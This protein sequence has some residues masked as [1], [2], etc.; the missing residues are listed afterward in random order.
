MSYIS[1]NA[2]TGQTV[3]NLPYHTKAEVS[4]KI[5]KLQSY[6]HHTSKENS[7]A[8]SSSLL[9][10]HDAFVVNR[11]KLSEL[12][13]IETGKPYTQSLAEINQ[14]IALAKY[15]HQNHTNLTKTKFVPVADAK[16]S[17]YRMGASGNNYIIGSYN[18]PFYS[19]W[20]YALPNILIGNNVLIR[21]DQWTPLLGLATE[22]I[23]RKKEVECAEFAF[24][25]ETDLE[26]ILENPEIA[27]VG[28]TGSTKS[29]N[30][31]AQVAGKCLKPAVMELGSSNAMVV[32]EDADLTET[33]GK[34]L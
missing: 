8:K 31:I 6:F 25:D 33:L 14:V 12:I 2:F 11:L 27:G 17:G 23:L 15:Y 26:Y 29:G 32:F 21:P 18:A 20:K 19:I 24:S 22:E 30:A 16:K 4:I 1:R 13:T 10:I 9:A 34:N 28:F 3:F 7:S 5:R